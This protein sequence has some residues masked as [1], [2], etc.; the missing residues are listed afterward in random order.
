M[1]EEL[2][3][4]T[5]VETFTIV[6]TPPN[7]N[8]IDGKWVLRRKQDGEGKVICWK[9]RYVVRGFQQKFRTDFTETFVPTVRP[10][11]LI[12]LLSIA[13]QQ[14]ATIIQANTK[15]AYLHGQNDT[16]E[17]FYMTIPDQYLRFYDLPSNL[18][19]LPLEK[20]SCRVWRPLYG[21]RQDAYRFY[22]FLLETL[23]KLGFTV[24]TADKAVFTSSIQMDHM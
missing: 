17:V 11:T 1:H 9:A 5:K 24:S 16:N 8:V 23:S 21:G 4:I 12:I 6:K 7:T 2:K 22:Q 18:S 20:L 14:N 19:H 13:A 3:Q 15:N 10:A